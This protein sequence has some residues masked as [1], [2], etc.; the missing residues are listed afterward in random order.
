MNFLGWGE[1]DEVRSEAGSGGHGGGF[2]RCGFAALACVSKRVFVGCSFGARGYFASC[3]A[4]SFP[5]WVVKFGSACCEASGCSRLK[6]EQSV[7][8]VV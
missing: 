6:I 2:R 3:S 8:E 5:C 1:P 4:R 7:S